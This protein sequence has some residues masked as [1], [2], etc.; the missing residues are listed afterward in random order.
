MKTIWIVAFLVA[1]SGVYAT[2]QFEDD[3]DYFNYDDLEDIGKVIDEEINESL[4]KKTDV[5]NDLKVEEEIQQFREADGDKIDADDKSKKTLDN[6]DDYQI[7]DNRDESK[8]E[9]DFKKHYDDLANLFDDAVADNVENRPEPDDPNAPSR[10]ED[11]ALLW[12]DDNIAPLPVPESSNEDDNN[13]IIEETKRILQEKD[14][15]NFEEEIMKEIEKSNIKPEDQPNLGQIIEETNQLLAKSDDSFDNDEPNLDEG[16]VK[17]ANSNEKEDVKPE[18]INNKVDQEEE[19]KQVIEDQDGDKVVE[20]IIS[21]EIKKSDENPE[22]RSD[23]ER[24]IE[25][26]NQL[27][28]KLDDSFDNYDSNV[29]GDSVETVKSEEK[30]NADKEVSDN[31]VE[32]E[33]E[34]TV[35]KVYADLNADL[36]KLFETLDKLRSDGSDNDDDNVDMDKALEEADKLFEEIDNKD[37]EKYEDS[38]L[39]DIDLDKLLADILSEDDMKAEDSAAEVFEPML[40]DA[41]NEPNPDDALEQD[42]ESIDKNLKPIIYV[43]D[44]LVDEPKENA[45]SLENADEN[46]AHEDVKD[47]SVEQAPIKTAFVDQ[48]NSEELQDLVKQFEIFHEDELD[49][50]SDSFARD[51][52]PELITLKLDEPTVINSH[53]TYPNFYPTNRVTDWILEGPGEG[54][55]LNI[56]DFA[57][58]GALG[59]FLLIKPGG[60]DDSGNDGLVFTYRLNS[61]RRYRFTDVSRLFMRFHSNQGMSFFRGFSISAKMIAPFPTETGEPIPEPEAVV[62]PPHSTATVT[63]ALPVVNFMAVNDTFRE[64]LA[65]MAQEYIRDH[66]VDPGLNAT[67]HVTQLTRVDLCPMTWTG[68]EHCT[69]VSFGVSLVYEDEEQ[70]PRLNEED[71]K[72]M[73]TTYVNRDPFALRLSAMGITEFHGPSSATMTLWLVIAAGV[74]LCMSLLA[75]VL[76]RYSCFEGYTRM[77]AYSDTESI[78]T[79]KRN[80]DLYPTPHQTLPPLY[81]ESLAHEYKWPEDDTRVDMGG[82]PNNSYTRENMYD[83]DSDEDVIATRDR[84]GAVNVKDISN[85]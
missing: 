62:A 83:F 67:S 57:V 71:L 21:D 79:E 84:K 76:W 46:S 45:E 50:H 7:E 27:L 58:N 53:E 4:N 77:K 9:N 17:T 3:Y 49:V 47:A 51:V 65:D 72:T 48:L 15:D 73:W 43:N 59:D 14:A 32:E 37:V 25:E 36:D 1:I 10:N 81:A 30:Q 5:D 56:T 8:E 23:L 22:R 35:D 39:D 60:V 13:A 26:T 24:I 16:N 69:A 33:E 68:Y 44:A 2:A 74:V 64:L 78:V 66:D 34:D 70:D 52:A 55:E 38:K 40:N 11:Y 28:E 80:L 19:S 85:V 63:L 31:K 61:E 20:D 82:F 42:V 12:G 41:I 75:F 6:I 29:D 18:I 54:I